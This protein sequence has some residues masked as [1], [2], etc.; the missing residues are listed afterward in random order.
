MDN[1]PIIVK[2][3]REESE[4]ISGLRCECGG[5]F[6]KDFQAVTTDDTENTHIFYDTIYLVCIE[7]EKEKEIVFEIHHSNHNKE[8]ETTTDLETAQ[9]CVPYMQLMKIAGLVGEKELSIDEALDLLE[10]SMDYIE[11][12]MSEFENS[13]KESALNESLANANNDIW[14]G[15]D[16]LMCSYEKLGEQLLKEETS[17]KKRKIA[18]KT[19]GA[20]AASEKN[21]T[22]LAAEGNE[23]IN[24]GRNKLTQ[25]NKSV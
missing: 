18:E 10:E 17:T 7:C 8:E 16:L 12:Q 5:E 3:I 20:F 14:D 24:Q 25:L 13:E 11:L 23:L 1:E 6:Q 19:R 2:D 4:I 9:F 22:E 21:W 15:L